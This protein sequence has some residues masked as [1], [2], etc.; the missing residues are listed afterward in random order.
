MAS[1]KDGEITKDALYFALHKPSFY[2]A[3][4]LDA[5]FEK[6]NCVARRDEGEVN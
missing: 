2:T 6:C 4:K 1:G 3:L 5:D